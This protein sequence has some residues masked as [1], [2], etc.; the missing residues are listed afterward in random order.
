MADHMA[1]CLEEG[2]HRAAELMEAPLHVTRLR[3]RDADASHL[4]DHDGYLFCA[5]E[6][7]ASV[8]GEMKDFF[9]RVYYDAFGVVEA[10]D[11]E[12]VDTEPMVEAEGEAAA[13]SEDSLLHG[14]PYGVAIA[15]GSD[16]QMAAAQL[17][18]ICQGWRL[19]AVADPL[20]ERNG[21][22]QTKSN[23]L[24][25]GKECSR[26]GKERCIELGGLVAASLLLA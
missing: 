3:A 15:A 4:L 26:Q 1:S 13:Y 6:N 5:P 9:D 20:V 23:I 7:L 16:G 25:P 12:P 18:R 19:R 14:R 21:Y 11:T 2:A 24:R 22:L 10:V 8:S 17:A